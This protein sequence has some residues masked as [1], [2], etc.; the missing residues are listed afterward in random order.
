MNVQSPWLYIGSEDL[1]II[2]HTQDELDAHVGV[3]GVDTER[4]QPR[5]E[6]A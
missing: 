5:I 2:T 1:S 6:A 4:Y 3:L